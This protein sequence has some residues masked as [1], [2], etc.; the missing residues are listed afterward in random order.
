MSPLKSIF[1]TIFSLKTDGIVERDKF[2]GKMAL[3]TSENLKLF[4]FNP[5]VFLWLKFNPQRASVICIVFFKNENPLRVS[6]SFFGPKGAKSD[7]IS[8]TRTE[9]LIRHSSLY[10]LSG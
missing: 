8:T 5:N 1:T 3:A 7:A 2:V 10:A 9:P 4:N 6:L